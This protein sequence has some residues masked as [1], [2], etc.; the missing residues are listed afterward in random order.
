MW[1]SHIVPRIVRIPR[2]GSSAAAV[3]EQPPAIR[4]EW[5]PT[6]LVSEVTTRSAP[7]RRASGTAARGRYCRRRRP[8]GVRRAPRA[9]PPAPGRGRCRRG[10][11]W[12][13]PAFEKERG[14]RAPGARLLDRLLHGPDPALGR[15]LDR[16]H[17]ELRQDAPQ[18]EVG[19]A[20]DGAGVDDDRTGSRI[21]P[22]RGR[23][24]RHAGGEHQIVLRLVPDRQP[25]LEH[26]EIGI[27]DPAV[28]EAGLLVRPLG[29]QAVG[30]FEE[31]LPVLGR[32]E[33][34][35]RGAKDR[36][37]QRPLG[38]ERVVSVAHHQGFRREQP[39]AERP[40][41][42]PFV[43]HRNPPPSASRR[44]AQSRGDRARDRATSQRASGQD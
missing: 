29:A 38:Q 7:W 20:I 17:A 8:G 10:R 40:L 4:S 32:A 21:G 2:I 39:V 34:E 25:V 3:P 11:W 15:E 5:P 36:R 44:H 19:A 30:Q 13:W 28:D 12:D 22:E 1:G 33:N 43:G 37:L 41:P 24:R 27:V 6:Y 16:R 31:F 9:H 26:F 42:P 18:Q 35:G 14:D 23:D